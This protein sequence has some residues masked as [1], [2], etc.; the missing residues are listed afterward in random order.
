MR[1][2]NP[3]RAIVDQL[4]LSKCNPEKKLI[5]LSIGDPTKFGEAGLFGNSST[6]WVPPYHGS[7]VAACSGAL[8]QV[9]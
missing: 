1:V 5:P 6:V 4:D 9:M 7:V 3:I 2:S 8:H